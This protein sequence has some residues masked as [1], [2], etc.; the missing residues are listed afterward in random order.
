MIASAAAFHGKTC[1]V[2]AESDHLARL[3]GMALA[4][5]GFSSIF[6]ELDAGQA[7]VRLAEADVDVVVLAGT[8]GSHLPLLHQIRN[9]RQKHK[10][11]V[12]VVCVAGAWAVQDVA[13]LRDA[14]VS[15][16]MTLPLATRT[17]FRQFSRLWMDARRFV[18]APTYHGPCRRQHDQPNYSG[19]QR[20]AADHCGAPHAAHDRRGHRPIGNEVVEAT[21]ADAIPHAPPPEGRQHSMRSTIILRDIDQVA[22]LI[23]KMRSTLRGWVD[24]NL[25]F[26]IRADLTDAVERLAN[27]ISLARCSGDDDD[28]LDASLKTRM[29]AINDAFFDLMARIAGDRVERLDADLAALLDGTGN[30]VLGRSELYAARL[31]GIMGI[32]AVIGGAERLDDRSRRGLVSVRSGVDKVAEMEATYLPQ[33]SAL[34]GTAKVKKVAPPKHKHTAEA[35]QVPPSIGSQEAVLGGI[36]RRRAP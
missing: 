2:V 20:R 9:D 12:P 4:N 3:I 25:S 11:T 31:A 18:N 6:F 23:D 33:V 28:Y 21:M 5:L 29:Q 1:F 19:P 22:A 13:A 30:W 17:V 36:N 27:L 10:A 24:G 8:I 15:L 14:G 34:G 26:E 16:L 7:P 32:V 35:D